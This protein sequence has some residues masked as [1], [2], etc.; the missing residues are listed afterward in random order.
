MTT[1]ANMAYPG[2]PIF[3]YFFE[4]LGTY[5]GNNIFGLSASTND[6]TYPHRKYSSGVKSHDLGGLLMGA[7]EEFKR[8][9]QAS[10]NKLVVTVTVWLVA[11]FC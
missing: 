5:L 11:S 9:L 6:F 10:F 8:S 1:G 2:S 7:F 3:D 4:H